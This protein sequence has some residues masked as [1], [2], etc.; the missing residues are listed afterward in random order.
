[1]I[2]VKVS[3]ITHLVLL[4]FSHVFFSV[5]MQ[6]KKIVTRKNSNKTMLLLWRHF[7]F[8]LMVPLK[9]SFSGVDPT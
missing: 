6:R 3:T 2:R 8:Y 4:R 9:R 7:L 5:D 1:M